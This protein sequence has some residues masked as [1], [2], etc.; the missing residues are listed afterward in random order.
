MI[1]VVIPLYNK[2]KQIAATLRSVLQQTYRDFEIVIIDDGSTDGSA[3]AVRAV[4]DPR[5]RLIRQ[6]NAGASAARNR[7]I[8][9]AR[10]GFI[11]FLDADDRWKPDYL[12]T[13]HDLAK[14]YPQCSV[15]ACNY[16]FVQEDG[17]VRPAV[18]RKLPFDG[19]DGV[20]DNYFE[21]ASCSHPPICSISIMVRKEAIESI[22][23]FPVGIRSGEDLLTW[24]RLACKYRIAYTRK[25]LALFISSP[26]GC[27]ESKVSLRLDKGDSVLLELLD[28]ANQNRGSKD[29]LLPYINRWRKIQT[30]ILLEAEKYQRARKYALQAMREGAPLATFL[31]LFLLSLLPRFFVDIVFRIKRKR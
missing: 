22:G 23:G 1:S 2:E 19:E 27:G 25:K 5:I 14:K 4:C 13:Q 17:T 9:E 21:V 26:S 3:A 12:Q 30:V 6:E 15:F 7:G 8:A 31:P 28:L 10:Y 18:I 20:L 11:A 16:E 24:A 29:D